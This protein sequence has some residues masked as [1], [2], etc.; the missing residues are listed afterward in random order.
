MA[1]LVKDVM[2]RSFASPRKRAQ[3]R[4]N[5]WTGVVSRLDLLGVYDR[6]DE[7]IRTQIV[8]QVVEDE[9]VLDSLARAVTV[10][11]GVVTLSGPVL[12]APLALSLLDAVRRAGRRCSRPG[13]AQL[14]ATVDG[15]VRSA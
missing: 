7:D 15:S 8:E 12:R 9:F 3:H 1:T 4:G 13:P 14:S 5:A 11:R 10:V 2:T 6:P